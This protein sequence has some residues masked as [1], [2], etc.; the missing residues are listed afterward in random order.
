[1]WLRLTAREPVAF[2]PQP[3][4]VKRG[5]H[6]D[7]LSRS[8]PVLD[9]YRIVALEKM[10]HSTLPLA[11]RRAV[12]EHLVEKCRIVASGAR[13]RQLTGRWETYQAKAEIYCQQLAGLYQLPAGVT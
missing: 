3:L 13:K 7:Q 4:I 5:G 10:L 8:V 11:Q 1:L 9:Q 6:A 12:L 2:V